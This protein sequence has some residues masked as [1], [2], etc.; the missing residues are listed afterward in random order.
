MT[1]IKQFNRQRFEWKLW[2]YPNYSHGFE[3]GPQLEVIALRLYFV[4]EMDPDTICDMI[5]FSSPGRLEQFFK[6]F[7]DYYLWQGPSEKMDSRGLLFQKYRLQ[8]MNE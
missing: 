3:C 4:A 5:R 1:G 2:D 6:K 8:K 7:K